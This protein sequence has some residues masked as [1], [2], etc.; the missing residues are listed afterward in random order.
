MI[1]DIVVISILVCVC[2]LA[3]Y[4]MRKSRKRSS[5]CTGNCASCGCSHCK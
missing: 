1:A 5:K 4:S 3:V 2:A